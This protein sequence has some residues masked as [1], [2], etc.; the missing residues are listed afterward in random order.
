M[1]RRNEQMHLGAFIYYTGHHHAGW[2]HPDSAVEQL[3]DIELYKKLAETAE[4]GKFDILFFA[5][6]LYVHVQQVEQ[7][8]SGMLDPMTLLPA[9]SMVTQKIGLAATVSTT[10][11]E[12]YNVARKFAS[13]DFI[14]GGRS[15]WNIVTSQLDVEARNYGKEKHP[16]HGLRYEMA[17]EFVDV[18]TRL[19]DSWEDDALVLNR[20]QG[21]FA[22]STK[23]KS[24]DYKGQWHSTGGPLNVPRPPQ[25]Y[26]VLIQAGSSEPGQDFAA[27]YGEVIFTAQTSLD[28]AKAFYDSLKSKLSKYGRKNEEVK[29]MPGLSPVIGNTEQEAWRKY[30]ELQ[31]LIPE[32]TAVAVLSGFLNYDLSGLSPDQPLPSDIP[33][34]VAASNGM[35][36]RIQLLLDLA[37][38]EKLSIAELGRKVLASRGHMQFVGTPEQLADFMQEW[39]EGYGCDGF[40]IMAP[41]LPGGLEEFVDHV[42]PILQERGLFRKDYTGSTLREHLGLPR[43]KTG[44]FHK[45]ESTSPVLSS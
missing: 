30:Y 7:S 31:A 43:P 22:D 15:A 42:I 12:P 35:K 37:Y 32:S 19:W 41:V 16:E 36:S 18:A 17:R 40:N 26:P 11:N 34:P 33:D 13:L 1:G 38:K 5:D 45:V 23:V 9:L 10:Y 20:E 25:G 24:V 21:R 44:H 14:S 2:R 28:A 4:R 3:F 39:Y 29:I 27:E 6:L 8:V